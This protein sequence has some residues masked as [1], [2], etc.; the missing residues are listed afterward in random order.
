MRIL[1]GGTPWLVWHV[2]TCQRVHRCL[3]VDPGALQYAVVGEPTLT[4]ARE[5]NERIERAVRIEVN[6]STRV[7]L[8]DPVDAEGVDE[9]LRVGKPE[10]EVFA[11]G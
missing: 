10:P 1:P 4:P 2:P 6:A 11:F 9:T 7:I 5:L 3:W 8:I